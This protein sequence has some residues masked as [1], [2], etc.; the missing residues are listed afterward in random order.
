MRPGSKVILVA[1]TNGQQK[2][3]KFVFKPIKSLCLIEFSSRE[4]LF[5][6]KIPLNFK[7]FF[8]KSQGIKKFSNFLPRS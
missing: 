3:E 8:S 5:I 2:E 4:K 7:D 6:S 1:Q